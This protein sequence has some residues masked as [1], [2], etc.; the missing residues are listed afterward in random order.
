MTP[1]TAVVTQ[2][3]YLPWLGYFE[4]LA[5]ADVYVVLDTV[6]L[7]RR[8]WQTRNR[9]KGADGEP[10]W[11]TVPLRKSARDT[12]IADV[13]LADDG[14]WRD[15]HLRAIRSALGT[16]PHFDECYSAIEAWLTRD[17]ERL[18]DLNLDGIRTVCDLLG[19]AP[20]VRR[21]SEFGFDSH[22]SALLVDLCRAVGAEQYYSAAGAADYLEADRALFDTAGIAVE[23]QQWEHPVYDQRGPGFQARMAVVDPIAH[24]GLTDIA[25]ALGVRAGERSAP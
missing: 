10:F 25:H 18:V 12:A 22:R 4:A 2:P 20:E 13:W 16:A 1:R 3:T 8:S 21:A 9:L 14:S 7:E 15:R 24:L 23:Y 5:R 11:L 19:I 17:H 6:Q